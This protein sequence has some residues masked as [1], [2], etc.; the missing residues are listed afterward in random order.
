M[1][2]RNKPRNNGTD[3]IDDFFAQFDQPSTTNRRRAARR[4]AT[5]HGRSAARRAASEDGEKRAPAPRR[6][7]SYRTEADRRAAKA[8]RRAIANNQEGARQYARRHSGD[9]AKDAK[10]A[11]NAKDAV[12]A[13]DAKDASRSGAAAAGAAG[14]G[15]AA[16][17]KAAAKTGTGPKQKDGSKAKDKAKSKD[18]DKDKAKGRSGSKE[19]SKAAAASATGGSKRGRT[20]RKGIKPRRPQ[21]N[22]K[23]LLKFIITA[24]LA[25]IMAVGI[26]VGFVFITAPTIDTDNIY[27][28][29]SER[30][31]LYDDKG[32][33]IESLY[34][35][36]GNRTILDYDEMPENMIN[37]VVSIEDQKFWKHHGF[38]F[39]RIIGAIKDSV[40]GGG[41]ISGTSTVTQQLARNVYLSD[42]KSKRS[43]GRKLQEMYIT[44]I[45]EKNMTKKKIME[46]YLNSIY[47]G[48]NSYG[49]EAAAQ[50]YFS[51]DAKDLDLLECAA[52]A[53]LPKSPDSYALV[54]TIYNGTNTSSLPVISTNRT[55]TYLYN[56]ELSEDRRNFTL[57]KMAEL[58][59]I[60]AEQ[61]D[62]ALDKSLKKKIKIGDAST[63]DDS[64]YFT[65]YCIDEVIEDVMDE[66]GIT[67]AEAKEMIYT[68]GLKVYTTM[69]SN[70]QDIVEE[71]FDKDSN[72]S[73]V[74]YVRKNSD[75]DI[76]DDKGAVLLYSYKKYFNSKNN[77]R[78]NSDEFT[79]NDDGGITIKAGKRLALFNTEVNGTPD[80]SIEFK[81]MYTMKE[82]HFYFI[83][84]GALSIPAQYKSSD[85]NGNCVISGQFFKDYPEFFV[86]DGKGLIVR[87][88][89]YSL[90]QEVRQPQ[91]A[92]VIMEND[93]GELKAMMGGRGAIGKQL[94]NRATSTRQPGS[95]IKP[96]G[97][98]GPALQMSYEYEEADKKMDLDETDGSSWGKYITAGSQINDKAMQYGGKTWPKNWYSGY[99]GKMSLR[100]SVEQSVNVNAVKTYLQIGADYSATML[101]K[102]GITSLDE[103]GSVN[104]LNPAAL[105]L[106]GM[107][108]GISPLEITAAYAVFPNKGIYREPISYTKVVNANDEV[109]FEKTAKETKV[110]DEGVAWIM[111]DILHTVVTHGLGSAANF[112]SQPVGGKTGTTTDSYD[113]WFTGFT[114]QYSCALWQG[115]DI[116]IELSAGSSQSARFWR[117]IMQRVCADIP[118]GHFAERPDNVES[119]GGEYYIEGTYSKVKKDKDKDKDEKTDEETTTKITTSKPTTGKPK[120]PDNKPQQ[121]D[122]AK[123]TTTESSSSDDSGGG[124]EA[125]SSSTDES[126]SE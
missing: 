120:K 117:N 42:I 125:D 16:E 69:D 70:I 17:A 121:T 52:L 22:W 71:E 50:S 122:P 20:T 103:E 54:R 78:L 123:D 67:L 21:A 40:F 46:A 33:E 49:V 34:Y 102:V 75:G 97:V 98:Y 39:T 124:S 18:K 99:K 85:K 6:S 9:D 76:L 25:C 94:F 28:Q 114:P 30:S 66:Y 61:R 62:K 91:A 32:N 79:K 45:L 111:T 77:F 87:E 47:M 59:Y 105:A 35:E 3:N 110:Y 57:N 82:G 81:S 11:A 14:S 51:K 60:T 95:N 74:G 104:D 72:Y 112:Y 100:K 63:A 93:T 15:K 84:N 107:T 126:S 36:H 10:D 89:N 31:T 5:I 73:G 118:R 92:T 106:G 56:G 65:D 96:I 48:F 88:G 113:L 41:Q 44:I 43:M 109:L 55:T 37:A 101:K 108:N 19:T 64:S 119:R 68:K 24:G 53:A 8:Q 38:N 12:N 29:L 4:N 2:D 58:G 7:T 86:K 1:A 80:I 116:N 115:N 13:K 26:Y 27:D 83:E 23:V 90:K